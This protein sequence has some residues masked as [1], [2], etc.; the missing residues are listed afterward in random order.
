M[1]KNM[2]HVILFNKN[3]YFKKKENK[4]IIIYTYTRK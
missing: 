2:N 3:I 1:N 4:K